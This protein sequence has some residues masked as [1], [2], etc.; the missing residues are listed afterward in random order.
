MDSP[1][2]FSDD[3]IREELARLGFANIPPDKLHE[4]QKDLNQLVEHERSKGNSA[5]TS[6]ASS[7]GHN[8]NNAA[9][10]FSSSAAAGDMGA[11]SAQP[12]YKH[13]DETGPQDS[14]LRRED[15]D[16]HENNGAWNKTSSRPKTAPSVPGYYSLY[17]V[18]AGPKAR[19]KDPRDLRDDVSETDSETRRMIKRKTLRKD[20]EGAKFIDESM[21]ESDAGSVEETHVRMQRLLLRDFD[22]PASRRP[23]T[24]QDP[25]PYRLNPNDPRLAMP[26]VIYSSFDHPH[27]KNIRRMDPV[28]RWH[29]MQQ[30]WAMQQAPG[31]KSRKGLRWNI[32]EQMLTQFVPEKKPPRKYVP[33][34]YVP[35]PDKKRKA[36][37]WQVRMD[38]AH[39]NLPPGG[40]LRD[41]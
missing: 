26:S 15:L 22:Y 21:T 16:Q 5:N 25:P 12:Q 11:A 30:A 18:Q 35:P 31:E 17:E 13:R 8:V 41:Y 38:M 28:A 24:A 23:Q 27:T 40:L 2:H 37:R 9:H 3:E 36:L 7:N 6:L 20:Q 1:L 34:N 33:N 32:K 4:F 19:G 39:G 14:C 10:G 29:Q